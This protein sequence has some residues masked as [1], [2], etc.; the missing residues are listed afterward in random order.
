MVD[1]QR[2]VVAGRARRLEQREG[3][4]GLEAGDVDVDAV[5]QEP[6]VGHDGEVLRGWW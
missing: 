2:G 6:E 5:A 1:V 4:V 3:A